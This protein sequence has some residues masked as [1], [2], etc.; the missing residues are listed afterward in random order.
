MS[1]TMPMC[2]ELMDIIYNVYITFEV[3]HF[4]VRIDHLILT[5]NTILYIK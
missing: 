4:L 2:V 3:Q 1:S 5:L